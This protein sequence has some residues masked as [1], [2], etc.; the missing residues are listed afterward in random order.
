MALDD[1]PEAPDRELVTMDLG[2]GLDRRAASGLVDQSHL[3]ECLAGAELADLLSVDGDGHLAALD[4]N[5]GAPGLAFLGDRL[6]GRIRPLDELAGEAVEKRVVGIGEEGDAANQLFAG[7]G[8]GRDPTSTGG[9][10]AP[11]KLESGPSHAPSRLDPGAAGSFVTRPCSAGPVSLPQGGR[12][13]ACAL[14]AGLLQGPVRRSRRPADAPGDQ[15]ISTHAPP[16][17]RRRGGAEDAE[18][19]G[20]L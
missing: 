6:A 10:K 5:E 15:A 12:A 3:A 17:A 11:P 4:H 2:V 8:H 13:P 7:A 19:D 1:R 16:H 14:S 18:G 9:R 20:A